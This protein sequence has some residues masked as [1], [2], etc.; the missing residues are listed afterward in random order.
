M[1]TA[2]P[3][4]TID[5]VAERYRTS[6]RAIHGK[7]AKNAIPFLKRNGFKGLLFSVAHLDAWDF[8]AELEV[9]ALPGGGKR[10]QP[11]VEERL[12]VVA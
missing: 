1:S 2:S 8:G 7:T 6:K 12:R 5:E 4:L 10:V 9:V 3:F 11:V